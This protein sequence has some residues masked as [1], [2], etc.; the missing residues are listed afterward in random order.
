MAT[1]ADGGMIASEATHKA[2]TGLER[3]RD[4]AV[5][6]HHHHFI[7]LSL[8]NRWLEDVAAPAASGVLLDYGCGG[9][10]YRELFARYVT[11]YLGA[12]IS[13]AAG[14]SPDIVVRPGERLPLADESIDTVLSTQVLEHVREP[15]GY[16]QE[17]RRVLKSGGKLIITVPMQWRHHEHPYDFRR[18]TRFGLES[19]LCARGFQI[20]DLRPCGGVFALVG[21]I[22]AN[23]LSARGVQNRPAFAAINRAALYFDRRYPDHDDTLGWMCIAAAA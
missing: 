10:P 23:A 4:M 8:M 14:V 17:C 1:V 18:F 6:V 9:Q 20:L 21:Q 15:E 3:R 7:V 22:L 5:P 11:R 13:P 12:D 16:I 19:S 2:L